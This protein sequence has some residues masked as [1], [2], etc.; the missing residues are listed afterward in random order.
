MNRRSWL[1]AAVLA[2]AR[3]RSPHLHPPLPSERLLLLCHCAPP[4]TRVFPRTDALPPIADVPGPS[5]LETRTIHLEI[6]HVPLCPPARALGLPAG[7]YRRLRPKK[8]RQRRIEQDAVDSGQLSRQADGH[9]IRGIH[10]DGTADAVQ[11][12]DIRARVTGYLRGD[13]KARTLTGLAGQPG[14]AARRDSAV[15][16]GLSLSRP[17]PDAIP[18]RGG[19]P[20]GRTSLRD[21]SAALSGSVSSGPASG[22]TQR[23]LSPAGQKDA[24]HQ[25]GHR[26]ESAQRRQQSSPC[27]AAGSS[28]RSGGQ[29][30]SLQGECGSVQTQPQL[31]PGHFAH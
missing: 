2:G 3:T 29:G 23:C 8:R 24:R 1:S 6:S 19:G 15:D 5:N 10:S 4:A 12:V 7:S 9:R 26:G 21:R 22:R 27:S 18:G 14:V 30:G 17:T 20:R 11:S 16:R 31:H 28:R 25:P 13:N